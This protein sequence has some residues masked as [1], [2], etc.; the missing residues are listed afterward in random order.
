MLVSSTVMPAGPIWPEAS[1]VAVPPRRGAFMTEPSTNFSVRRDPAE[2]RPVDARRVEGDGAGAAL[3]GG[4]GRRHATAHRHGHDRAIG[5]VRP[6][7]EGQR[8]GPVS[9]DSPPVSLESPSAFVSAPVSLASIPASGLPSLE[10]A[11]PPQPAAIAS[12]ATLGSEL[13]IFIQ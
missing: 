3:A 10:T 11:S 4:E 6:V 8:L 2:V 12:T 1:V 13:L 5:G 9:V 7:A